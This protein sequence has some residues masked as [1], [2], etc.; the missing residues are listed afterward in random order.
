MSK[1]KERPDL[2]VVTPRLLEPDFNAPFRNFSEPTLRTP[3][4]R[5]NS[6]KSFPEGRVES[7]S[8]FARTMST[9][10]KRFPVAMIIVAAFSGRP[11]QKE[12]ATRRNAWPQVALHGLRI[13]FKPVGPRMS[14]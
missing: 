12:Q 7:A 10:R 1:R 11:V 13:I 5:V 4:G 9:A 6:K 8:A 2:S 3:F 14:G